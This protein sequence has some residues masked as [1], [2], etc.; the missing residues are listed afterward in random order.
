MTTTKNLIKNFFIKNGG[1]FITAKETRVY[2]QGRIIYN[3]KKEGMYIR[4]SPI[5]YDRKYI[6][7]NFNKIIDLTIMDNTKGDYNYLFPLPPPK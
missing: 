5:E 2:Q 6:I 7:N 1:I 3:S 4:F